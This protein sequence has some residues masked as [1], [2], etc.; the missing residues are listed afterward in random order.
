MFTYHDYYQYV[1]LYYISIVQYNSIFPVMTTLYQWFVIVWAFLAELEQKPTT[2]HY[3][4]RTW[5]RQKK[6]CIILVGKQSQC[7]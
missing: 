7:R 4:K 3:S 5:Y 1:T 6:T 2:I